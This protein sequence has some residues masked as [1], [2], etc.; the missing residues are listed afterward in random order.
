LRDAIREA[1]E[2]RYGDGW[3][4][5]CDDVFLPLDLTQRL[6]TNLLEDSLN[7]LLN[8]GAFSR[9]NHLLEESFT[10]PLNVLYASLNHGLIAELLTTIETGLRKMADRI[11]LGGVHVR[12]SFTGRLDPPVV[13]Y[14]AILILWKEVFG[15]HLAISRDSQDASK[16]GGPLVRY[17]FAVTRPVMVRQTPSLQSLPDIVDRQKRFVGWWSA[18][19]R[20]C[21]MP[22]SERSAYLREIEGRYPDLASWH[23]ETLLLLDT[24]R[25]GEVR[26]G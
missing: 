9:L 20:L 26:G 5:A 12:T 7:T 2:S 10:N 25:N 15:G 6:I 19:D 11:N 21:N 8:V 14:Q 17:F 22:L 18:F 16:I 1:A 3:A 24:L 13:Y 23:R 4:S